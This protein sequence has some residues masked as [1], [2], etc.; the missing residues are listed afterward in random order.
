[1]QHR[2]DA[3]AARLRRGARGRQHALVATDGPRLIS[4]FDELEIRLQLARR[5]ASIVTETVD[6]DVVFAFVRYR[7]P[8]TRL[9][10][11][12][13]ALR[14][15]VCGLEDRGEVIGHVG[16]PAMHLQVRPQVSGEIHPEGRRLS[17]VRN[18]TSMSVSR[19]SRYSL[20][21]TF[22]CPPS[23]KRG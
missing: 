6:D 9:V 22:R 7:R 10:A 1:M 11:L 23:L 19:K 13:F 3:A 18:I 12:P 20:P 5:V 17:P 15:R 21:T 2:V 16:H 14:E 8:S 4:A